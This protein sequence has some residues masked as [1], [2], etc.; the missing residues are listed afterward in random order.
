MRI[1]VLRNSLLTFTTCTSPADFILS[2]GTFTETL[3]HGTVH[4][5][6]S[7]TGAISTDGTLTADLLLAFTVGENRSLITEEVMF[8]GS[9]VGTSTVAISGSYVGSSVPE[10][11]SVILF[12]TAAVFLLGYRW[13]RPRL[14]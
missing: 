7:G 4:G 12:G 2:E 6:A 11:S 5:T 1:P 9:A 10:P 8:T 13:R 3:A 14:G